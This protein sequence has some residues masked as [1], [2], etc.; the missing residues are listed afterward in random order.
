MDNKETTSLMQHL[1][2]FTVRNSLQRRPITSNRNL[3]RYGGIAAI[4]SAALYVL[5]LAT[6]I[7]AG[8]APS[9]VGAMLTIVSTLLFLLAIFALYV[10]HRSESPGLSLIAMLAAAAGTVGGLFLDPTK[11]TPLVGLL[12]LVYGIG[13][14][15]FGWLAYRSPNMPRVMG[16]VIVAGVLSLILAA[17]A[18]VGGS[19]EIFGLLNLVLTVPYVA[20]LIWLGLHWFWSP[21][22][23]Q[24]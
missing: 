18:F 12:A 5:V 19:T 16:V 13:L 22:A 1:G 9:T 11:I 23:P 10:A 8:G 3:F 21:A 20:W 4:A 2:P 6:A 7:T 24:A 14:L 15:L 17:V